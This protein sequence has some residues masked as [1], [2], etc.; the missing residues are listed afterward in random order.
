MNVVS[1]TIIATALYIPPLM[2]FVESPIV[3]KIN[4]PRRAGEV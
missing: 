4:P 1:I 3:A 2:I